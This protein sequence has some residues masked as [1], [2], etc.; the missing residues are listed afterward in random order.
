MIEGV[1]GLVLRVGQALGVFLAAVLAAGCATAGGVAGMA[2]SRRTGDGALPPDPP[3]LVSAGVRTLPSEGYRHVPAGTEITFQLDPPT[4]GPHYDSWTPPGFYTDPQPAGMLVHSL[5]HGYVVIYYSPSLSN[6]KLEALHRLVERVN[7]NSKTG[8]KW[9]GVVAV[10]G[11]YEEE[12]VLTAWRK[13]LRLKVYD[14]VLI[15]KFLDAYLGRGP[16]NPVRS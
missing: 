2:E 5:E 10:P 4:S 13:M 8:G 16:E 15:E 14:E 1:H 9:D 7:Q 12:I 11:K 6:E 3:E